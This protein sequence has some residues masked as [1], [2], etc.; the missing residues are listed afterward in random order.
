VVGSRWKRPLRNT[1]VLRF[2]SFVR[3]VFGDYGGQM[4]SYSGFTEKLI[5]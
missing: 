5:G 3:H 4:I 2:S 1:V